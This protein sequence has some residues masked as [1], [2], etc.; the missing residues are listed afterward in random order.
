[1]SKIGVTL[2]MCR[3]RILARNLIAREK[4][5]DLQELEQEELDATERPAA[6]ARVEREAEQ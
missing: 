5:Q 3:A 2:G 4:K 6:Q 1:M